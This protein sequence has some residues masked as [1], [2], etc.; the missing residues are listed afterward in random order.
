LTDWVREQYQVSERRACRVLH[1]PRATQRYRSVR[2]EQTALRMRLRELAQAPPRF[3]YRRLWVLLRREGWPINAKRVYRLY[4]EEG[5]SVRTRRRRK[6]ASHV[7]LLLP[8]PSSANERWPMDLVSDS[9]DDGRRFRALTVV[10][11]YTRECL[12]IE[13]GQSLTGKKVAAVGVDNGPEFTGRELDSWAYRNGV[14]LDFIRP[15]RPVENAFIES[16]NGRLRD[17][18]LNGELFMS[19]DDAR[20]KIET[21]RRDYNLARPHSSLGDRTPEEFARE[22]LTNQSPEARNLHLGLA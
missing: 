3:G 22:Q 21:W 7:R 8:E 2:P 11:V 16:F 18:C 17:E 20:Q 12:A 9:L 19:L 1:Q 10:D 5:L 13:F 15:G 6:R 4:R 14:K